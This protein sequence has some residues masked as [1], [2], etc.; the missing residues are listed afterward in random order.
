MHEP[1]V[2]S[3]VA[4]LA[5]TP[6]I[7]LVSRNIKTKNVLNIKSFEFAFLSNQSKHS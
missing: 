5:G 4:F 1:I 6:L 7:S 3:L 2:F